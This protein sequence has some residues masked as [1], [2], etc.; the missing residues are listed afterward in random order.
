V[1]IRYILRLRFNYAG[2]PSSPKPAPK[3]TTTT[4]TTTTASSSPPASPPPSSSSSKKGVWQYKAASGWKNYGYEITTR[5]KNRFLISSTAQ[6]IVLKYKTTK[7]RASR[8]SSWT[9]TELV[10]PLI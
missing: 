6:Q 2:T 10:I 9:S 5:N 4:T 8:N 3:K 7:T 1:K